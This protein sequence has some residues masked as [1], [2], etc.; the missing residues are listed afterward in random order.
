MVQEALDNAKIGRTCIIIAHR[1][2]TIQDADVICVL[3]EGVVVEM[4]THTELLARRGEYYQ[5]YK[6]QTGHS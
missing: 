3:K 4:G 1:L 5:F 2:T 6:L